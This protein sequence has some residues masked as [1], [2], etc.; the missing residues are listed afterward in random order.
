[1]QKRLVLQG[2][3]YA[4]LP[5]FMVAKELTSKA[6]K[7]VPTSRPIG[8]DV[9]IVSRRVGEFSQAATRM[10]DLLKKELS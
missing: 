4:V 1:M 2:A 7:A 5:K 3:G 6:L 8:S 10:A 9:F